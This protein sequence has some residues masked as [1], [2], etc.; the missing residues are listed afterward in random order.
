MLFAGTY[1]KKTLDMRWVSTG[2]F[3][4]QGF[5]VGWILWDRIQGKRRD[6]Q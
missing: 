3:V 2:L 4:Y 6:Y 1:L 5:L